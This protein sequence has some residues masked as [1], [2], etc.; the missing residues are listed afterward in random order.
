MTETVGGVSYSVDVDL[1]Q[2]M[3]LDSAVD[4]STK[5]MAKDFNA[6][7]KS[8]GASTQ[9]IKTKATKTA[10]A[11][12]GALSGVGRS[13]GQAGVQVQ[14]FI[15]QLQGGQNLFV[16]LSQQSADLGFVLGAP[17]LGAL[18][19]IAAVVGGVLYSAMQD[20]AQS[21]EELTKKLEK[22]KESTGLTA[23]QSKFLSEQEKD[24]LEQK[25]KTINALELQIYKQEKLLKVMSSAGTGLDQGQFAIPRSADE[26][27]QRYAESIEDARRS[28]IKNKAEIS[29]LNEEIK[30]SKDSIKEYETGAIASEKA[31][32]AIK[33]ATKDLNEQLQIALVRQRDGEVAALKL[34]AAYKLGLKSIEMLPQEYAK[35]I[36]ETYNFKKATEE[37]KKKLRE[38]DAEAR[39]ALNTYESL[40]KTLRNQIMA[41]DDSPEA[42][43]RYILEQRE[44]AEAAKGNADE[45]ES[46]IRLQKQLKDAQKQGKGDT[47]RESKVAKL[48]EE[49]R[50]QQIKVA[51]GNDEFEVQSAIAALGKDAT[52]GEIERITALVT[53]MQALRFEAELL[54]P[55]LEQSFSDTMLSSL[56]Q[57][58]K[59]MADIIL[60]GASAREVFHSLAGTIATE[61]LSSFIRYYV[62]RAAAAITSSAQ[63]VGADATTAAAKNSIMA[64]STAAAVANLGVLT[65]AGLASA[66][67][68]SAAWG[69]AAI[70]ASI[71]TF[72]GAAATAT[73]IFISSTAAMGGALAATKIAGGGRLYGGPVGGGKLYPFM[74]NGKPE[75]LEMGGK[76]YLWTGGGNGNVVSNGEMSKGGGSNITVQMNIVNNAS[77]ATVESGPARKVSDDKYIVDVVVS[78]LNERGRIHGAVTGTTTA[79]NRI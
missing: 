46:L 16:A 44:A 66:T 18:V 30:K 1:S 2:L 69:T 19:S 67:A 37:A 26:N 22:L 34:A 41:L 73:P 75:A 9:G 55:A 40:R 76:T 64:A 58:S 23:E 5:E 52:A 13:A 27:I 78:N 14:Q 32:K 68:L 24:G 70:A 6:L 72:G 71:A 28:I 21:V 49:I 74:E 79:G 15:G 4:K 43:E 35:L 42:F 31:Q 62:G 12:S 8:I 63:E 29:L 56:D 25:Y 60:S 45:I 38:S 54:G 61:L 77:G 33:E 59:G 53:Q 11:V 17:L 48:E 39:K 65:A 57:F 10:S 20:G 47:K 36:E 51:L 3:Q 50:L 7:D